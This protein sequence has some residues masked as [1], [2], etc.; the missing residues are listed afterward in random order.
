VP[1]P[2]GATAVLANKGNEPAAGV[3]QGNR[4]SVATPHDIERLRVADPAL[5]VRWR[6]EVRDALTGAME[7]GYR[8]TGIT[9][10]GQYQLEAP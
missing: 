4:V 7:A 2:A 5:A 10:D 1:D 9:R 8:I 6:M 3:L